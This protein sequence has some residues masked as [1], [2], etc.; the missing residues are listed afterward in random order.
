MLMRQVRMLAVS[1]FALTLVV[2][3]STWVPRAVQAFPFGGQITFIQGCLAD[4]AV[5]VQLSGPRGGSY[6]WRSSTHTYKFGPP[7]H[8]GQWLLGLAGA[9]YQCV[10]NQVPLL[11]YTGSYI[12]MMGSSQ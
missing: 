11:F 2:V 1:V 9:P 7:S 6:I 8:T 12:T 3:G 5:F 10:Y 4:D